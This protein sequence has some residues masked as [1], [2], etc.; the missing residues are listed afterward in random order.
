M[1]RTKSASKSGKSAAGPAALN[2]L[3]ADHDAVRKLFDQYEELA[4]SEADADDRQTLAT[5]LCGE[6]T[7]HAQIEEEIFYPALRGALEEMDLLDEAEVEHASAKDLIEQIEGMSPDEE[8][9]DAKVT[10]LG[11]YIRH[12]IEEEEGE[13]FKQAKKSALDFEAI[14]E[15]LAARREELRSELGLDEEDEEDTDEDD[16]D[17][18]AAGEEDE[19]AGGSRSRSRKAS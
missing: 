17:E 9:F 18:E 15:E 13:M 8:L 3:K 14:G 6:L 12:H 5:R 1:A 11:E 10:V 4:G 19:E 2:L 7:V 16:T